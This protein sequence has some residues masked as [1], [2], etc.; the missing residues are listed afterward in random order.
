MLYPTKGFFPL[1]FSIVKS[2]DTAIFFSKLGL[3]RHLVLNNTY[4]YGVSEEWKTYQSAI[5][6]SWKINVSA[7]EYVFHYTLL[8]F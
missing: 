7:S 4:H 8:P 6:E 2:H 5:S 3:V 1:V